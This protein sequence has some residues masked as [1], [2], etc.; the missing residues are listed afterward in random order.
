MV[1]LRLTP[2]PI[3]GPQSGN[4]GPEV[5]P[6]W[7]HTTR[8]WRQPVPRQGSGVRFVGQAGAPHSRRRPLRGGE[9][10]ASAHPPGALGSGLCLSK[11]RGPSPTGCTHT[12]AP[13]EPLRPD[14]IPRP[15]PAHG[16][17]PRFPCLCRCTPPVPEHLR[18]P[19]A[20]PPRRARSPFPSERPAPSIPRPPRVSVDLSSPGAACERRP[21]GFRPR[22]PLRHAPVPCA[23]LCARPLVG[24]WAVSGSATARGAPC[25]AG[26]SLGHT[27]R[28]GT[29]GSC[30]W[31]LWVS[32]A[33]EPFRAA[34]DGARGGQRV[35][36]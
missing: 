33:E 15:H 8:S 29:A 16:V 22:S 1:Q 5:V 34:T 18:P 20:A 21:R 4:C 28:A 19:T 30:T 36:V 26:F 32:P 6:P 24:T 10:E 14:G 17:V 2:P 27:P 3:G 12:R 7:V 9:A 11:A 23:P 25:A 13:L 35:R 31:R